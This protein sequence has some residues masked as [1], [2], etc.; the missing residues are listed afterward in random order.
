MKDQIFA[1]VRKFLGKDI[2]K[3]DGKYELTEEIRN[4]LTEEF[5]EK[6]VDKFAAMLE[7]GASKNGID[8]VLQSV[9]EQNT[10]LQ[11]KLE[12]QT[13]QLETLSGQVEK[14]SKEPE[15][16][17]LVETKESNGKKIMLFK[18]NMK[19]SH[20]KV[21]K[22]Y[23]NGNAAQIMAGDTINVDDVITEF[24]DLVNYFKPEL[25]RSI[26]WEFESAKYMTVKRAITSWK[27]SQAVITSVIQQ[28]VPKWTPLGQSTFT[29]IEI[30]LRRFKINLPILPA[31]LEDWIY[32]M[33]DE[34][35]D[36]DQMPITQY[37]INNLLKPKA[38]EDLENIIAQ[39][40]FV[41][42]AW[43]AV[44]EGDPGQDPLNALDG[45]VT[46]LTDMHAAGDTAVNWLLEG[47]TITDDNIVTRVNAFA[48]AVAPKYRR[49]KMNIFASEDF[50][51][52]YKR[53]YQALYPN[54]KNLDA[55]NYRIDFT[56]FTLVGLPS[57]VGTDVFFATPTENFILLRHTN[58]PGATTLFLQKQNYTVKVF[59]EFRL[60]VGFAMKEAIFAY[61]PDGSGSGSGS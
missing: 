9:I 16:E 10:E 54:T 59:G 27:A 14:L 21:A 45:F 29:P 12:E 42:L 13:Q 40:N 26:M 51:I 56:N 43:G 5:G 30:P 37:I 22:E 34:G 17:P 55:D 53:R 1:I 2:P 46:Q 39:G 35:V 28:F 15:P 47:L 8:P 36:I 18:P 11:V 31:D 57:M 49:K 3:K 44:T 41:E 52:R 60:G 24:G 4:K 23:L 61:V 48:D 25:L 58:E 19:F 7:E 33:Y 20:N 38:I 50:V 6:F 32:Q